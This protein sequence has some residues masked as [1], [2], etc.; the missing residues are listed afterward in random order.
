MSMFCVP[1]GKTKLKDYE[2]SEDKRNCRRFGPCGAGRQALYL[3][4]RFLD[5]RFYIVWGEVKRVYKRVAMTKGGFTGK[6]VFGSMPFLIVEHGDVK[7]EFPFKREEDVDDLLNYIAIEHPKIPIYSEEA[8]KKLREAEAAEE[9]RYIEKL[10]REAETS[11]SRLEADRDFLSERRSLSDELVSAA[12]N[13]RVIDKLPAS[14]RIIGFTL[15]AL[16]LL[17]IV[18]GIIKYAAHESYAMYFVVGGAIAI[19]MAITSNSL[20]TRYNSKAAA[21]SRWLKAVDAM[22]VHLE[23]KPDFVLPPQYAHPTVIARTIRVIKEGRAESV[24]DAL[25]IMK[26]DLKALNSSVTVSQKEHD[27]VVEVKPLFLVCDYRDEI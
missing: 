13:K 6:G 18:F 14:F 23:Q 22:R 7:Q 26:E 20:P 1:I 17:G 21:N 5:R 9:S 11:V 15:L 19:L 2:L 12:K 10:S 16:G 8:L 25:E 27:E 4:G 24:E 3:N